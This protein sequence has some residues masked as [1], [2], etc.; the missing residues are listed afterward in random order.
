MCSGSIRQ[1]LPSASSKRGLV[2]VP[3]NEHP[4]DDTIWATT[5]G[6]DI[7]WYYNYKHWPS[8]AYKN[9][10]M[11]FVPMLWGASEDDEGTPFLDAVKSQIATGNNVSYVL[12]FNEPDGPNSYGGSD[13]LPDLAASAWKK[14]IEPLKEYGIKLGAPAVT[15]SPNGF[16]WLQSWFTACNGGCTPDF[17]PVHWY[18]DFEGMASHI[19]QTMSTYPN[20]T[21]WVTEWGY[22]NQSLEET[23]RFFNTS[24]QWFDRT[25]NVTHYSYFGAF[26]S[27]VSNIGPNSAMLTAEG[28]LTD[29]GSWYLGGAATNNLPTGT[30]SR[31]A[32]FAGWSLIVLA[33]V[34]QALA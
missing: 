16:V 12:G 21:V 5:P 1:E 33:T 30:S 31:I 2:H 9:S 3:S 7:S 8:E 15:G 18:G 17:I 22:P 23:Q 13:I 11:Q 32:G 28:K 4:E 26:R 20:M 14:Q 34:M 25:Q 6:S 27:D 29:I 10:K 24:T 19:G